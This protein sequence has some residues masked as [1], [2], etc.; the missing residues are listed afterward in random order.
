MSGGRRTLEKWWQFSIKDLEAF[1]PE[2]CEEN[3]IRSAVWWYSL[4]SCLGIKSISATWSG[5]RSAVWY[6]SKPVCGAA[7]AAAAGIS[8]PQASPTAT[9]SQSLLRV[10][11]LLLNCLHSETN[12]GLTSRAAVLQLWTKGGENV[13]V[14]DQREKSDQQLVLQTPPSGCSTSEAALI[15]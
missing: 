11:K 8:P 9:V 2:R 14:K 12:Q 15:C 1:P 3:E 4:I 13:L 6:K 7:A 10:D 5:N